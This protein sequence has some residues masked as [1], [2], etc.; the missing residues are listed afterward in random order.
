[1][2]DKKTIGA[3]L[4]F[5]SSSFINRLNRKEID[6]LWMIITLFKLDPTSELSVGVQSVPVMGA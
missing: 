3:D 4:D 6:L 1:M 5:S 2:T